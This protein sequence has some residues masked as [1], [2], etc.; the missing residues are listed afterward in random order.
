MIV[1]VISIGIGVE[2]DD[3]MLT[4]MAQNGSNVKVNSNYPCSQYE[5]RINSTEK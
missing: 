2:N 3:K 5:F 4:N 1:Q